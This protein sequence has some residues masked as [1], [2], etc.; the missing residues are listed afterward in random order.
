[1]QVFR[2]AGTD[3]VQVFRPA[4][5]ESPIQVRTDE[6][7]RQSMPDAQGVH[8]IT[9]RQRSRI[10][11][12]LPKVEGQAYRGGEIVGD[13]ERALPLGSSLDAVRGVFYWEPAPAFL[14]SYE[15]VFAA[16]DGT[17]IRVRVVVEP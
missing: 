14:G 17:P 1:V 7:T 2:P 13:A 6:V 16:G 15:L 5:N 9:L 10:E 11:V 4:Y 3:V 8:I 12:E